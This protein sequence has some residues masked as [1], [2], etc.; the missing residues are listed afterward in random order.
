MVRF[1]HSARRR[2]L[3]HAPTDK[4]LALYLQGF[5]KGYVRGIADVRAQVSKDK[6]FPQTREISLRVAEDH[7]VIEAGCWLAGMR[8][9]RLEANNDPKNPEA[10]IEQRFCSEWNS[11]YIGECALECDPAAVKTRRVFAVLL[12][13]RKPAL[14]IDQGRLESV[15]ES[16]W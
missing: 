14:I 8:I 3:M 5:S 12:R 6:W 9:G 4:Q 1:W 7:S 2:A 16:G 11:E 13:K 15:I 10:H